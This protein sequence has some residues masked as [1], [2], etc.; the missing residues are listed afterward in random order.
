MRLSD[1]LKQR[2]GDLLDRLEKLSKTAEAEGRLFDAAESAAWDAATKEVADLDAQITRQVAA[3]EMARGGKGAR[4][5]IDD[6]GN[7]HPILRP[8]DKLADRHR[9]SGQPLNIAR[10]LRG[11]V[12]GD[13]NGADGERRAMGESTLPGG[14]Y[15]VPAELSSL[16]L[17]MARSRSVCIAAGGGTIEMATQTLRIAE[18]TQ[19]VVP[20]FR[21]ENVALAENDM[22]FGAV[23][24]RARLVGVV[25][26]ASLELISDSPMASDMITTSITAALG[27][28]MDRAGLSGD[29]V[30]SAAVDNPTGILVKAGVNEL[31]A[32]GALTDYD[33]YL[34]AM[35]LV[36]G[37][38]LT[39]GAAINSPANNNTLRKL[40]T[41]IGSTDGT[42]TFADKSK[43]SAPADYAALLRLVTTSMPNTSAIVGDFTQMAFGMREGIV[44][45][46]TRVGDTALKNAQIL[47]RGYAR[48]DV[49]ILRPKGFTRL[50]GI[51]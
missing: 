29:G 8:T 50:M 21:P 5:A 24:L 30:V 19:D 39:P 16:W 12:T 2:R 10:A 51:A 22:V 6:Q 35:A 25:A 47:I 9:S 33:K 3:E 26:R 11:I 32:V 17:D 4:V 49:G 31:L 28:A 43:L 1:G 42:T 14:G 23:D 40:T 37:A 34:D 38:N 7:R 45:E 36:E 41:G 27:L 15:S 46:A 18:I 44:I 13:W 20:T 48:L